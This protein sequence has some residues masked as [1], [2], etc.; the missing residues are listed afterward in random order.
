MEMLA[1]KRNVES[2]KMQAAN[3]KQKNWQHGLGRLLFLA[4]YSLANLLKQTQ[5]HGLI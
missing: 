2:N 4:Q 1:N 3:K 5:T